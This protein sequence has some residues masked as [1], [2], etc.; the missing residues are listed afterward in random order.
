[1]RLFERTR[2]GV[3]PTNLGEFVVTGARVVLADMDHLLDGALER[4]RP[5]RPDGP[6]RVGGSG[7]L[8]PLFAARL[9]TALQL[10]A[11][12]TDMEP[13]RGALLGLI[14]NG[15]IDFGIIENYRDLPLP[16]P[17]SVRVKLLVVEPAFVALPEGHPLGELDSVPL[18]ELAELEWVVDPPSES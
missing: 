13:G 18:T 10:S 3:T 4:V 16:L 14:N 9:R 11:G 5:R 7:A 8:P 1:G 17:E 15:R 2:E 12:V 6:V